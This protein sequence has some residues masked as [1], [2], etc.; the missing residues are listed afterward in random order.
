MLICN[1]TYAQNF[2]QLSTNL[3][4]Y[5]YP[6]SDRA[7]IDNDGDLDLVISGALDTNADEFA[8]TSKIDFYENINGTLTL[9]E[10]ADV[11]DLHLGSV[12][13]IDID[14]D[15][16]KDSDGLFYY[17]TVVTTENGSEIASYKVYGNS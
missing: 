17:L 1:I 9:M 12:I 4:D 5:W 6:S 13:F 7:D 2:T 16:D 8:D 14:N 11:N 15:G 10:Q 3:N